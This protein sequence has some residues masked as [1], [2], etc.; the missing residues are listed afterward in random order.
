MA[1]SR[2]G[3]RTQQ[4]QGN[5]AELENKNGAMNHGNTR[6]MSQIWNN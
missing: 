5:F 1:D 2:A 6:A 4:D 3:A